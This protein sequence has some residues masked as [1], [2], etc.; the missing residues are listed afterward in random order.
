M[1]LCEAEHDGNVQMGILVATVMS[2]LAYQADL[3]I[4]AFVLLGIAGGM[5]GRVEFGDVSSATR[6]GSTTAGA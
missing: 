1:L 5:P 2:G 4:D 6:S 3:E